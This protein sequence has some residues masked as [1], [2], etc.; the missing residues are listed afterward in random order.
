MMKN[1]SACCLAAASL[2]LASCTLGEPDNS[3]SAAEELQLSAL[4]AYGLKM[5]TVSRDNLN[6]IT[7]INYSGENIY[8]LTYSDDSDRATS[9]VSKQYDYIYDSDSDRD[10][11][12]LTESEEWTDIEYNTDGT[13]A[14]YNYTETIVNAY[15]SQVLETEKGRATYTYVNG[16]PTRQVW[17]GTILETNQA[18]TDCINFIWEGDL[19]TGWTDDPNEDNP[20][21]VVFEYSDVDN[22]HRQWEPNAF[23]G[24]LA[25]TGIFGPAPSKFLKS[26]EVFS[27]GASDEFYQYAY[28]LLPNGLIDLA[29]FAD[30][31]GDTLVFNYIYEKK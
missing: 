22:I 16:H 10:V 8:T 12:K 24:P 26:E 5:M 13:I 2:T 31:D 1:L 6:R 23:F 21:W 27:N 19:M 3:D 9:I 4:T 20:E 7:E 18:S 17:V 25:I 14:T 15:D 28:A 30:R 11:R 29:K